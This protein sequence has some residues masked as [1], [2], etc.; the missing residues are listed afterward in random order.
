MVSFSK[1]SKDHLEDQAE[2]CH[3]GTAAH[4]EPPLGQYLMKLRRCSGNLIE[5]QSCCNRYLKGILLKKK[6]KAYLGPQMN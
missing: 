4:R 6:K 2:I 1:V 5:L 3:R